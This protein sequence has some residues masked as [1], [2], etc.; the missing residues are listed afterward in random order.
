MSSIYGDLAIAEEEIRWPNAWTESFETG[1]T[2]G[3]NSS[4]TLMSSCGATLHRVGLGS[5]RVT[6]NPNHQRSLKSCARFISD[7]MRDHSR[8]FEYVGFPDDEVYVESFPLTVMDEFESGFH[9]VNASYMTSLGESGTVC[10]R[11][12]KS[13]PSG[14][15]SENPPTL[16]SPFAVCSDDEYSEIVCIR[17]SILF[18][19]LG[20]NP[21]G[22]G[23]RLFVS[24]CR[25][26]IIDFVILV[27]NSSE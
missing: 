3:T 18:N 13:I 21:H 7:Y 26:G 19:I 17:M 16:I 2:S 10:S 23:V 6:L 12:S 14:I 4:D 25:M 9:E 8:I 20:A 22:E 11:I 1:T 15:R 5:E 27:F 24:K